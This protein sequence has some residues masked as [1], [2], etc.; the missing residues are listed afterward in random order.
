MNNIAGGNEQ[1]Q[2][3][4]NYMEAVFF[5]KDINKLIEET[6]NF[7]ARNFS[8]SNAAIKIFDAKGRYYSNE[9]SNKVYELIEGLIEKEIRNSKTLIYTHKLKED[10]L[11]KNI[12]NADSIAQVLLAMPVLFNNEY[13]GCIFIYSEQNIQN[14][15]NTINL[16][17]E[18]LAKFAIT[19]NNYDIIQKSAITDSLTGLY[20]RGFLTENLKQ[21]LTKAEKENMPTSLVMMDVDNFKRFNDTKGHLEGDRILKELSNVIKNNFSDKD[22]CCRYGGEEFVVIM[23][24]T[25]QQDAA[26]KAEKLRT[27]VEKNCELTIS[28]GLITSH[29][30]SLNYSEM[31]QK[32]D[33]ALYKAK[34][35]GKNKLVQY[36]SID[37]NIGII[38]VKDAESIGKS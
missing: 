36:I 32:A 37:K 19:I 13:V 27:D 30:S 14:I 25:K 2:L 1:L 16:I 17:S 5:A 4:I 31:L 6:L 22:I 8:I 23:A 15:S 28:I 7:L 35:S 29:N 20:N 18:K 9:R 12:K 33:E 11:T 34:N 3:I 24:E 38:D 21:I 26:L 10:V